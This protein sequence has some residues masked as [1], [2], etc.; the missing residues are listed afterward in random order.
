MPRQRE[1]DPQ[2]RQSVGMLPTSR[3]SYNPRMFSKYADRQSHGVTTSFPRLRKDRGSDRDIIF[4]EEEKEKEGVEE[5]PEDE[6]ME[7]KSKKLK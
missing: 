5:N 1:F 6:D 4:E 2:S 3:N 7:V